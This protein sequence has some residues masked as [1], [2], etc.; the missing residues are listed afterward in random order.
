MHI[1]ASEASA[2][3]VS[4]AHAAGLAVMAWFPGRSFDTE[5]ELTALIDMVRPVCRPVHPETAMQ[6]VDHICT[7]LPDRL[8]QIIL[9]RA[10]AAGKQ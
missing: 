4:Q 1:K 9:A 3:I 7:N 5:A 2:A 8:N 6:G 10:A